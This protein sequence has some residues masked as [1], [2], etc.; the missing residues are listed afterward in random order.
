[1]LLADPQAI[2]D[3]ARLLDIDVAI[4]HLSEPT[5]AIA[6]FSRAL[7]VLPLAL[8]ETV[9]A[10]QPSTANA[11]ATVAS[12]TQAVEL[13]VAGRCAAVVTNPIAKHV[14]YVAA[15]F[16]T[17]GIRNSL[18]S[19]CSESGSPETSHPVMMLWRRAICGSS[20]SRSTF[21]SR[22]FPRALS[23]DLIIETARIT[24]LRR[25]R[26]DFGIAEPS[27]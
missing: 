15:R 27:A 3:R 8:A 1:M 9:K 11:T 18:R 7:P 12:I 24:R 21:R 13:V 17:R 16:A 23:T 25:S 22:R 5:Q 6:A 2:L 14:L 10:G 26:S 20:P 4:E 19:P